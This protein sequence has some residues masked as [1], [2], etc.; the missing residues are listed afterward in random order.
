MS[1]FLGVALP[2]LKEW[3]GTEPSNGVPSL[4]SW[5]PNFLQAT[6]GAG[7]R[8]D[9]SSNPF[10][11]L[12]RGRFNLEGKS[13]CRHLKSRKQFVLGLGR[14]GRQSRSSASKGSA[15]RSGQRACRTFRERDPPFDRQ[16][17]GPVPARRHSRMKSVSRGRRLERTRRT[18]FQSLCDR[19]EAFPGRRLQS[20]LAIVIV[21]ISASAFP[22][23]LS[24]PSGAPPKARFWRQRASRPRP[25]LGSLNAPAKK[26]RLHG[27]SLLP[28]REVSV[29]F[30]PVLRHSDDCAL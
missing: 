12:L 8:R 7:S 4:L 18:N 19:P 6:R 10:S 15:D 16:I 3:S 20:R 1:F 27:K 17:H 21:L 25:V 23:T 11:K 14:R 5:L 24:P 28:T 13:H 30:R 9:Y 29:A 2:N 26:L 22:A